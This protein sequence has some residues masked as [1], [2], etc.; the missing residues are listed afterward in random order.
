MFISMPK[1]F[2]IP[3]LFSDNFELDSETGQMEYDTNTRE[4]IN[5]NENMSRGEGAETYQ[6]KYAENV[7]KEKVN[8]SLQPEKE[9][10]K[11]VQNEELIDIHI[12]VIEKAIINNINIKQN[13]CNLNKVSINGKNFEDN[14]DEHL[15]RIEDIIKQHIQKYAYVNKSAVGTEFTNGEKAKLKDKLINITKDNFAF[16][17]EITSNM[18]PAEELNVILIYLKVILMYHINNMGCPNKYN[19][20][21][22][23][24]LIEMHLDKIKSN[25]YNNCKLLMCNRISDDENYEDDKEVDLKEMQKKI[26]YKDNLISEIDN[27][28]IYSVITN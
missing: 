4:K 5:I 10:F 28:Y 24:E 7:I 11:K 16:L 17:N 1:D 18:E 26:L 2:F 3:V 8:T 15:D 9:E 22:I 14:L 20:N 23:E 12:N 6:K 13:L 21:N 27:E 25:F 19:G